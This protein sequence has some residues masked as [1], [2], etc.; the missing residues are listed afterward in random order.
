MHIEQAEVIASL[1]N[2]RDEFKR[3]KKILV[4]DIS[5]NH[6]APYIFTASSADIVVGNYKVTI[7]KPTIKTLL[8]MMDTQCNLIEQSISSLNEDIK[9]TLGGDGEDSPITTD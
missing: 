8:R 9:I 3:V 2:T 1:I 5:H 6:N 7:S 4:T